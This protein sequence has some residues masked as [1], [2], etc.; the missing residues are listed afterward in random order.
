MADVLCIC[1]AAISLKLSS[2]K[3][4]DF[5]VGNGYVFQQDLI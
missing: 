5:C 2:I 3:L 1:F 4:L